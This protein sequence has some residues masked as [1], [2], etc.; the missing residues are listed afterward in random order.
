METNGHFLEMAQIKDGQI[1]C[2][3]THLKAPEALGAYEGEMSHVEC[4]RQREPEHMF[5]LRPRVCRCDLCR[6]AF[7]QMNVTHGI[8]LQG[9]FAQVSLRKYVSFSIRACHKPSV[10]V[11]HAKSI[12]TTEHLGQFVIPAARIRMIAFMSSEHKF[13]HIQYKILLFFLCSAVPQKMHEIFA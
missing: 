5:V 6:S 9:F 11:T 3:F 1:Y 12:S 10:Y 13:A 8:R 4:E 2:Q 7:L